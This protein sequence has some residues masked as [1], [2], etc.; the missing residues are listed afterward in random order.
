MQLRP[1][2]GLLLG[3]LSSALL[4]FSSYAIDVTININGSIRLPPCQINGNNNLEIDFGEVMIRDINDS[5][6]QKPQKTEE[7]AVTCLGYVGLV[8]KISAGAGTSASNNILIPNQSPSTNV[9]I[10]LYQG[11]S[12]TQQFTLGRNL[13]FP[14][15]FGPALQCS[16]YTCTGT[17]SFTAQL[18]K[19]NNNVD[20]IAGDFEAS[21]TM[22]LKWP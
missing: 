10:A 11:D 3:V 9:G 21:A 18:V 14:G 5:A 8:L 19:A 20:V 6:R 16:G 7:L 15:N 12:T 22:E 17:L 2:I 13:T 4:S 1:F